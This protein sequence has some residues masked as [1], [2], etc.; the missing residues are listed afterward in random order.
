MSSNIVLSGNLNFLN[1]GEILQL[2]GS[3]GSSGLLRILSKYAPNPG[4][5]YFLNGNPINASNGSLNGIDAVYSLFGW[6][7]GEFEFS[8]EDIKSE[9]VIKFGRME[10]ILTGLKMLDDGDI[11]KLGP[12]SFEKEP[13]DL[14]GKESILPIIKGPL[15][16]YMD[17]VAEEEVLDGDRIIE[18]GK[19]GEWIWVILEGVVDIIKETPK[20]TIKIVRIGDGSFIGSISSFL[21]ESQIRSATAVA[22]GNVQLGVLDSQRLSNELASFSSEFKRLVISLDNRLKEVTDK[23]IDV[24]IKKKKVKDFL[25]DK[26]LVMKTDENEKRLFSIKRGN[27]FIVR[28]TDSDYIHLS[29]LNKE[30]FFGHVPFLN[31]G[32]EPYSAM[33]FGSKDLEIKKLGP[34]KLQKEYDQLSNTFKN[35]IENLGTCILATTMMTC[36]FQKKAGSKKSAKK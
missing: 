11:E 16:D 30:D 21:V 33:V 28:K 22:A 20:E 5:I 9:K 31:M 1:L 36:E 3:N 14:P 8:T 6:I 26:K 23:T 27:A 34:E 35:I 10:I 32:H 24:Y 25:K 12:V 15:V 18:E 4:L 13:S 29:T 7:E 17:V 2:L 19:H